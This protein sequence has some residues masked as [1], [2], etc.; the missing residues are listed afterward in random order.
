ME[1]SNPVRSYHVSDNVVHC[2]QYHVLF[3]TKWRTPCAGRLRGLQ[4]YTLMGNR[5]YVKL[6]RG[7]EQLYECYKRYVPQGGVY[8]SREAAAPVGRN[9]A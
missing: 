4:K 3:C 9:H 8:G 7:N 2:C 6:L 5:T 1:L